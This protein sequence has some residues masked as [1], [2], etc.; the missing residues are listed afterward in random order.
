[1][2]GNS[3]NEA[4]LFSVS[5]WQLASKTILPEEPSLSQEAG[6][7]A[8]FL[9]QGL[10]IIYIPGWPWTHYL[11]FLLSLL[12]TGLQMC[13]TSASLPWFSRLLVFFSFRSKIP[14]GKFLWS[15]SKHPRKHRSPLQ[16]MLINIGWNYNHRV[17]NYS[18][19]SI[20][21]LLIRILIPEC[22][23]DI[24]TPNSGWYFPACFAPSSGCVL[25]AN[26]T[27]VCGFQVISLLA[28]SLPLFFTFALD[29]NSKNGFSHR[30]ENYGMTKQY[31]LK[32]Q[33]PR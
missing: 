27:D 6:A 23:L 28:L 26:G 5:S 16:K 9:R 19:M 2:R 29:C 22:Y 32:N 11:P 3:S 13:T 21:P 10:A 20:P 31:V 1:M 24:Q 14:K 18:Q 25:N 30:E 33:V 8:L 4:W 17:F 12:S 15:T 7:D